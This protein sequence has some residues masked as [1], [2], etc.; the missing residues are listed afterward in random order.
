MCITHLLR[1]LSL[2]NWLLNLFTPV[3][4]T[5][6]ADIYIVLCE[7]AYFEIHNIYRLFLSIKV[8]SCLPDLM[9]FLSEKQLC[10]NS[11]ITIPLSS[12]SPGLWDC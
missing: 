7:N 12:E 10:Y 6:S 1:Y 8:T 4:F 9:F 2:L 3:A 5:Q 11:F